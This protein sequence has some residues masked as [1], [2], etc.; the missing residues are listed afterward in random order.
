MNKEQIL[1]IA[2]EQI[3]NEMNS[4]QVKEE[5]AQVNARKNR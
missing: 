4:T 3:R 1:K 2:L 5:A